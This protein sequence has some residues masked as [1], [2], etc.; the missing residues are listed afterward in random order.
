MCTRFN[1]KYWISARRIGLKAVVQ[2]KNS[3]KFFINVSRMMQ[4]SERMNMVEAGKIQ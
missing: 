4:R 1:M 2:Q 3:L